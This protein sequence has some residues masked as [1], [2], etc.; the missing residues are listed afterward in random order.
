MVRESV[1][2]VAFCP[3]RPSFLIGSEWGTITEWDI[4]TQTKH[5]IVEKVPYI[6][7]MAISPDGTKILMGGG[8]ALI[9]DK[10]TGQEIRRLEGHHSEISAVAISPNGKLAITGAGDSKARLWDFTT[11]QLLRTEMFCSSVCSATFSPDGA[12]ALLGSNDFSILLWDITT[13]HVITHLDMQGWVL[14]GAFNSTG[15]E[16]AVGT[17]EKGVKILKNPVIGRDLSL[18]QQLLLLKTFKNAGEVNPSES[19][20]LT[21]IYETL[22]EEFKK[23][24]D[25]APCQALTKK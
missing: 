11:G 9:I 21:S 12:T 23:S 6:N 5:V 2:A 17:C 18:P 3:N 20:A 19:S 22:P 14:S 24:I 13:G 16:L 7:S 15:N 1:M 10:A 25:N 4:A 8:A